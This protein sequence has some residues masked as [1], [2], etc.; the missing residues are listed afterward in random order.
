[1][2]GFLRESKIVNLKLCLTLLKLTYLK[3]M[4]RFEYL[5]FLFVIFSASMANSQESRWR[6]RLDSAAIFSSTRFADLNRDGVLDVIIGAGSETHELTS[7]VVA[8]D[9]KTGDILWKI[10]APTQIYTSALLQ[11]INNDSIPDIFIGGRNSCFY[12]IDGASGDILWEFWDGGMTDAR[13]QGIYNFYATQWI[14]DQ[15][16]DGYKDLLVANGGDSKV[17]PGVKK[18]PH[19]NLMVL[20]GKDGKELARAPVPE[21]R[22]VYYAPHVHFNDGKKKAKI[23]FATGGEDIDGKLYEVKLKKLMRNKIS[24]ARVLLSDSVKGFI[25]NSLMIDLNNDGLLDIVNARIN[26]T[27]TAI[28][29]KNHRVLWEHY[30]PNTEC[31]AAPSAGYFTGDPTPDIFLTTAQ[32][33]FPGYEAFKQIVIDGATGEIVYEDSVGTFQFSSAIAADLNND[34]WDEIIY[35]M[36]TIDPETYESTNQFRVIDVHRDTTY[37]IGG[38]R[39]GANFSSTPSLVDLDGDQKL[40]I[41]F[42][43]SQSPSSED[44]YSIIECIDLEEWCESISFPGYLGRGENGVFRG[45]QLVGD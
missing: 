17:M 1:L 21:N 24:R 7:G 13:S 42:C 3:Q 16:A 20:S 18:R 28:D 33:S 45:R 8:V 22:E 39:E 37:M 31:Y 10:S 35:L 2:I 32:G 12:A 44:K 19:G 30:F 25:V 36:N 6:V 43:Y 41:V 4:F 34:Q 23:I 11:D 38:V 9:G 14:E 26:G 40:E 5:I 29:G 27:I 15:N